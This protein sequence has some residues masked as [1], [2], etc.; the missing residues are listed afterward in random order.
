MPK[1]K[2]AL[3]P[4]QNVAP[5]APAPAIKKVNLA[6]IG[7]RAS[8]KTTTTYP[9]LPDE[10]GEVAKLVGDILDESDQL[11]ALETSVTIKK[12]ELKGMASAFYFTHHHGLHEIPSSIEARNG[13]RQVL[14][15]F[16]NRYKVVPDEAPLIAL[17]GEE[18]TAR[19]FRQGFD[20]KISGDKIPAAVADTLI[21]GVVALFAEH[22]ASEALTAISGIK[23]TKEFHTARHSAL[24]VEENAALELVCPIVGMVKTKGRGED[25]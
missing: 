3:P 9:V 18:R 6:G 13:E 16:Q 25:K 4:A 15:S 17:L 7:A 23:P 10:H 14:V 12:A 11:D 8:T 21:E 5:A 22:G 24:T 19:F 2:T 20:L 1:T